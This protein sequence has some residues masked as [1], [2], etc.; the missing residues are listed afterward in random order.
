M[1]IF[2]RILPMITRRFWLTTSALLAMLVSCNWV[3]A[4]AVDDATA[5]D[6][7]DLCSDSPAN[8]LYKIANKNNNSEDLRRRALAAMVEVSRECSNASDNRLT[9][10]HQKL[11]NAGYKVLALSEVTSRRVG[12]EG[13][14]YVI[15]QPDNV[16]P[17][18]GSISRGQALANIAL[19]DSDTHIR[20]WAL[21]AL[22]TLRGD[23]TTVQN[24]LTSATSDSEVVIQEA[25]ADMLAELFGP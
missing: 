22:V 9:Q 12:I 21:E 17:P 23:D 5:A 13:F 2:T 10:Y 16:Q 11:I 25:A 4:D 20:L 1:K 18:Q 8:E 6:I 15:M 7:A 14:Q 19:T 3:Y 24:T